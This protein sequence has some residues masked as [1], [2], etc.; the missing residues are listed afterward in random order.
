[1]WKNQSPYA[2]LVGIQNGVIAQENSRAGPQKFKADLPHDPATPILGIYIF[3]R[4][5]SRDSNRY[6]HTDVQS[7]VV[8]NR[9]KVDATQMS[10]SGR[11]DKPNVVHP[12][13]RIFLSL[14]RRGILAHT[15]RMNLEDIMLKDI[16]QSQE[17]KQRMIPLIG[18]PQSSQV[19][20]TKSRWWLPDAGGG[21]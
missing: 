2:P 18:G 8:H 3:Q 10:I 15:T 13:N 12:Y 14:K 1:M 4:T 9:Q 7:N 16:R 11:R 21:E 20:E 17:D 6:L 5:Q 19:L